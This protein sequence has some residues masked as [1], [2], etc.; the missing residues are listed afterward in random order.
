MNVLFLPY[1]NQTAILT[2]ARDG[3]LPDNTLMGVNHLPQHGIDF[4]ILDPPNPVWTGGMFKRI[5]AR[6]RLGSHI[7]R[8]FLQQIRSLAR[9]HQYD[10]VLLGSKENVISDGILRLPLPLRSPPVIGLEISIS[11]SVPFPNLVRLLVSK[12]DG[13]AV[14]SRQMAGELRALG[15]PRKRVHVLAYGVDDGFFRPRTEDTEPDIDILS[16]GHA[17]RDFAF[18]L[19]LP[20]Q[21]LEQ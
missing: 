17:C 9:R 13:L 10:C 7:E 6:T 4:D 18:I 5:R 19:L 12:A 20:T 21:F 1:S 11:R 15:V 16:L 2:Q 3:L 8:N 14:L